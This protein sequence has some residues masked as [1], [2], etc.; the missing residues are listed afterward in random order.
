MIA[1][2]HHMLTIKSRKGEMRVTERP[3]REVDLY[4]SKDQQGEILSRIDRLA[5]YPETAISQEEMHRR[6]KEKIKGY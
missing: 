1:N 3:V 6:I 4:L 2:S 5:K